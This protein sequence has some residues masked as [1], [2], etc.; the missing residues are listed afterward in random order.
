MAGERPGDKLRKLDAVMADRSSTEGERAAAKAA[1][2][3]IRTKRKRQRA[4]AE[5]DAIQNNGTMYLLGRV[6]KRVRQPNTEDGKPAGKGV[7][8]AFGRAWRKIVS[9][10]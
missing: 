1:A 2:D 7:M 5:R 6:L 3:R 9:K 4:E 10:S 8:Y